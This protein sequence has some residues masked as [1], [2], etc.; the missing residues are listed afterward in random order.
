LRRGSEAYLD[1]LADPDVEIFALKLKAEHAHE[2][3]EQFED[4]LPDD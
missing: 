3:L 4:S 1:L 2:A